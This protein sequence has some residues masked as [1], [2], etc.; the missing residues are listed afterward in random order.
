MFNEMLLGRGL[1]RVAYIYPP[2]V[3]YVDQFKEIQTKAQEVSVRYMEYREL[4][5]R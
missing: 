1:A 4:C 3:K 2:N 5:T